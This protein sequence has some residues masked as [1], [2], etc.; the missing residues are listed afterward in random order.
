VWRSV[1]ISFLSHSCAPRIPFVPSAT[2]H[3]R[4]FHAV[5]FPRRGPLRLPRTRVAMAPR[6]AVA[7]FILFAVAAFLTSH[8]V[9]HSTLSAPPSISN[10]KKC[11]VHF[12]QVEW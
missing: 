4:F 2:L 11:K 10:F 5:W 1:V 6:A 8:V 12:G 3:G 9:A 7:G